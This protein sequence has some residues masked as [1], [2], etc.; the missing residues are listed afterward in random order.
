MQNGDMGR[1]MSQ[2]KK[3][4]MY[5]WNE[6]LMEVKCYK[7]TD[8]GTKNNY[9]QCLNFI[10]LQQTLTEGFMTDFMTDNSLSLRAM[11]KIQYVA[12]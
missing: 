11:L 7:H 6:V 12:N 8:F 2:E 3:P 9:F 1:E 4:V 5:V 10:W